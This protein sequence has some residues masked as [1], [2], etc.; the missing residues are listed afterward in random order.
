MEVHVKERLTLSDIP[1]SE[2]ADPYV[3]Q[4]LRV[5]W[6][7]VGKD[8]MYAVGLP[9]PREE[10]HLTP[11]ELYVRRSVAEQPAYPSSMNLGISF[12]ERA[13]IR[14]GKFVS[15]PPPKHTPPGSSERRQEL[16]FRFARLE[17]MG[18]A[19][20]ARGYFQKRLWVVGR[21][22]N[23]DDLCLTDELRLVIICYQLAELGPLILRPEAAPLR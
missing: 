1:P 10:S 13:D 16:R 23:A 8:S 17:S 11:I 4:Y 9:V 21:V 19:P 22:P 5:F 15:S 14:V 12:A 3:E 2:R 7:E 18:F 6:R 20:D